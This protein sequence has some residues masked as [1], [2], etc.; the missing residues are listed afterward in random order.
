[1]TRPTIILAV[2]LLV[3]AGAAYAQEDPGFQDMELRIFDISMLVT[4]HLAQSG[5]HLGPDN[6]FW[7]EDYADFEP[8]SFIEGDALADL[9]RDT[10]ET[11]TWD[12]GWADIQFR[13]GGRLIV[14]NLPS[15]NRKIETFLAALAAAAGR[16]V[17]LSAALFEVPESGRAALEAGTPPAR[18]PDAKLVASGSTET[19][20]GV[21]AVIKVTNRV[22]YV[23][24]YDVEIAQGSN[25]SD[26]IV[27][28]PDEGF[29]LEVLPRIT[30]GGGRVVLQCYS[31]SG[32]FRRPFR[33]LV[34]ATDEEY[35]AERFR[36]DR[37]YS[38]GKLE[39]PVYD[40]ANAFFTRVARSG[41]SFVVPTLSEGKLL[42][43]V[44]T[45]RV[46]GRGGLNGLYDTSLYDIGAM[47]GRFRNPFFGFPEEM[48]PEY[49]AWFAPGFHNAGDYDSRLLGGPE[50]I[51]D[52]VVSNVT[53]WAWEEDSYLHLSGE[54]RLF[55]HAEEGLRRDVETFLREREAEAL[56]PVTLEVAVY[57]ITGELPAG[58]AE[59]EVPAGAVLRS[60]ARL[61]TL[62]HLRTGFQAGSL[63]SFLADYDVEVAQEARIADPIIGLAFEGITGNLTAELSMDRK[64]MSVELSMLLSHLGPIRQF[65]SGTQYLGPVDHFDTARTVLNQ[66][67]E[68][69]TG[70]SFWI[71]AGTDPVDPTRRIAVRIG[72][73][74][75]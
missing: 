58:D 72:G 1:M 35:F 15:V 32:R 12:T 16:R 66:T 61:D 20:S 53:P 48:E 40:H 8:E 30:L 74:L 56:V 25:L 19:R 41:E 22:R 67:I 18:I 17:R 57:S 69:A 70:G 52:L 36:S 3:A 64:R 7:E 4:P 28:T 38:H 24:D 10:I 62:P 54:S 45:P 14:R 29:T 43:L 65:L 13:E 68:M 50:D 73:R 6:Q 2:L 26:P 5:P 47:T 60:W 39:L 9:I 46:T 63:T 27:G 55:V 21:Q 33:S 31:Q 51:L 75:D 44:V 71:D 37:R 49:A 34:V 11:E 23:R 59:R 42:A